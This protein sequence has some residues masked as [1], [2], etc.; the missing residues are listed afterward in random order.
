[1]NVLGNSHTQFFLPGLV[2]GLFDDDWRIRVCSVS[3][4]GDLLYLVG[5]ISRAV[6]VAE[7]EDDDTGVAGN[8]RA[9]VTIRAHIGDAATNKVLAALYISRSDT[10]AGVRQG[11]LQVWKSIVSNTPKTLKEIMGQLLLQV[12]EKL[13]SQSPD[14]RT[15]AAKALGDVVVKMGD[16]VLPIVVPFLKKG[17]DEGD[18]AKREGI[19]LGLAEIMSCST[20]AQIEGFIDFLVPALHTAI[21]DVSAD[22]RKL[23]ANAF[24]TMLRTIGSRAVDDVVPSLIDQIEDGEG[25]EDE[26]DEDADT[27]DDNEEGGSSSNLALLGIRD[28]VRARPRELMEYLLPLLL[29]SPVSK[30]SA[31]ILGFVVSAAGTQLNYQ[32]SAIIPDLIP[33]L[34]DSVCDPGRH[35]SIKKCAT[36]IM[37]AVLSSGV[38]YLIDGTAYAS[39]SIL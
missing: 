29:E 21:C 17:L 4:L 14:M 13:S 28:L 36:K 16:H 39:F 3:L 19:C 34:E 9:A 23:G 6:G 24:Q 20:K 11:G 1:M 26:D 12:V 30:T 7:D 33:E 18:Q 38:N 31:R 37:S 25:E 10:S 35:T 27:L 22:V 15:I 8:S 32:F 2:D 5:D